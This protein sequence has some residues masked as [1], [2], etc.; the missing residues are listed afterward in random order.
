LLGRSRQG[1]TGT[2]S[3]RFIGWVIAEHYR[4]STRI[5]QHSQRLHGDRISTEIEDG[6]H[7]CEQRHGDNAKLQ[8]RSATLIE[9]THHCTNT[10]TWLLSFM[11]FGHPEL[12]KFGVPENWMDAA[13]TSVQ[14]LLEVGLP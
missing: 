3:V 13:M 4:P 8:G 10:T 11:S 9:P 2:A 1:V 12:S 5:R 7:Q 14:V 6:E